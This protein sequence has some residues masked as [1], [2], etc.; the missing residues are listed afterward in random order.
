MNTQ[1]S[2]GLLLYILF[3]LVVGGGY[4]LAGLMSK[5]ENAS[6]SNF[7]MAFVWTLGTL[8]VTILL[9]TFQ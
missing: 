1:P 3:P 7:V 9:L 5:D 4:T 6:N 2:L 8:L